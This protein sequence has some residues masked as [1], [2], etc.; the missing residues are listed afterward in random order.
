[1]AALVIFDGRAGTDF[2][3]RA[4]RQVVSLMKHSRLM[5]VV[6]CAWN[7]LATLSRIYFIIGSSLS[8]RIISP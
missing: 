7:G 3:Y 5:T 4:G 2:D 1:M 6:L 8:N